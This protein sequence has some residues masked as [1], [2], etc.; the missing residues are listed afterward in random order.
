[1]QT[2]RKKKPFKHLP[3]QGL[4]YNFF[5]NYLSEKHGCRVFKLP[6]NAGLGCPNRDGTIGIGG[7]IFCSEEGSSSPTAL[8]SD[9]II[10]QM[11]NASRSFGRTFDTTK[12]LAYFQA[13]TNT[14]ASADHLKTLF[15]T[16][17]A[18]PE[19]IG[20]M[21]GTRP[22]CILDEHLELISSYASRC[23]EL[24][25]EIGMQSI[26]NK[27]LSFLKRGHTY[28]DS[29]SA[30]HRISAHPI[31]ICLHIIL[32]IPGESWNEMMETA[33]TISAL[34]VKG[35]KIHHMHVIRDTELERMY[36]E[37]K[38]SLLKPDEYIS[39]LADFLE[40]IR[41]DIL[42]HRISGDCPLEKLIA[43]AWGLHKGSI[44]T[45]LDNE[46]IRR[47]TWQGFMEQSTFES[48]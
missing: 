14:Y 12:Y 24:W 34:P 10:A 47:G 23:S 5:G 4:P 25:L 13:F 42:I 29:L 27:S 43:P 45:N 35:I 17:L 41:P 30:I 7:C 26:H 21:I 22:D 3:W 2:E 48:Q 40:R 32:G 16:T 15:D 19:T 36:N 46:F 31:D 11:R 9:D 6:I 1:L 28:E 44:Q 39:T 8:C 37:K 18:F 33:Q 20:M 38:I